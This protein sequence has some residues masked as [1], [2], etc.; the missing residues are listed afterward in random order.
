MTNTAQPGTRKSLTPGAQVNVY[1]STLAT[2]FGRH[3]LHALITD[4]GI[5]GDVNPIIDLDVYDN[6]R[7]FEDDLE[8]IAS[9]YLGKAYALTGHAIVFRDAAVCASNMAEKITGL[10]PDLTARAPLTLAIEAVLTRMVVRDGY[11]KTAAAVQDAIISGMTA[12]TQ[13]DAVRRQQ[14]PAQA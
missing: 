8:L 6:R 7:K 2:E 5:T 4:P 11:N 9:N 10:F 3:V 13:A 1:R 12:F 14:L